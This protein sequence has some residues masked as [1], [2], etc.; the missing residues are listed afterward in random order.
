MRYTTRTFFLL[1]TTFLL[2]G[3]NTQDSYSSHANSYHSHLPGT[4]LF[5]T[6]IRKMLNMFEQSDSVEGISPSTDEVYHILGNELSKR[7]WLN[8]SQA[9]LLF[10]YM[11]INSILESSTNGKDVLAMTIKAIYDYE[12]EF[13]IPLGDGLKPSSAP[14]AFTGAGEIRL[15]NNDVNNRTRVVRLMVFFIANRQ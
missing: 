8:A 1:M 7:E 4:K 11:Q 15:N 12:M 6:D 9:L 14:R 3:C 10:H 13:I 2:M 5:S